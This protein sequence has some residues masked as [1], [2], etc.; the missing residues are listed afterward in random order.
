M[1]KSIKELTA[2]EKKQLLK[3][4]AAEQKKERAAR[5][6]QYD[7][8]KAEVNKVVENVFPL[9]QAVSNQLRIAKQKVYDS[10][11]KLLQKK[12]SLYESSVDNYTHTFTNEDGGIS[13]TIGH[14]VVDGWDD[15]VNAGIEKVK[16]YVNKVSNKADKSNEQIKFLVET[17]NRLL[18][19]D[20]QGNLQ[21]SR[22]LELKKVAEDIN[23]KEL[24]EGI[25]IIQS[26][27]KPRRT[28]TFISVKYKN[29]EGAEV[30]LP[31]SITDAELGV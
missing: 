29:K 22:V 10:T 19:K 13:L 7:A 9:L 1:S 3:E 24:Q 6:G 31:L 26:A 21:A 20:A 16:K 17:V 2:A 15:T 27:Y 18:S 30:A 8:Y 23:S 4:L 28:K 12:A 14:R 5:K 11:N 25:D